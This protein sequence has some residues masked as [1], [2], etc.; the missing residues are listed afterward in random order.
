MARLYEQILEEFRKEMVEKGLSA[1]AADRVC[2]IF[3]GS[4]KAKPERVLAALA[5]DEGDTDRVGE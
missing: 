1:A 5:V 4:G 3:K 2:A